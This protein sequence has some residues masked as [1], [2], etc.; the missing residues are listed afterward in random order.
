MNPAPGLFEELARGIAA[1]GVKEAI[2]TVAE[3]V[4]DQFES[5]RAEEIGAL[6]EWTGTR[7]ILESAK[8]WSPEC[9]AIRYR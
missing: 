3:G 5:Q 1:E 7:I 6:E 2:V 9:W 4:L 8:D